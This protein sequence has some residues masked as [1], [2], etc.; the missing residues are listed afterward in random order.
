MMRM[1]AR[2]VLVV[3]LPPF[4]GG[5]P[6]K[7]RILCRTLRERGHMVTVAWYA[8][9]R[10]HPDLNVPSWALLSGRRPAMAQ[11]TCFGD[12][13]SRAVGCWL[14]EL[15]APYYRLSSRWQSLIDSH[16]RHIAVGGPPMV[17]HILA[18]ARVPHLLWCASDVMADRRDRQKSMGLIRGMVDAMITRPWLRAQQAY[19]LRSG[20]RMLGVSSYTVRQLLAHGAPPER[21][22]RLPIPVD[23][24]IFTPPASSAQAAILGFAARF[25]DPRK[26]LGLLLA[27]VASTAPGSAN[28]T[29][30]SATFNPSP[31]ILG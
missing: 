5:V 29:M 24:R 15:E 2:K 6:A 1:A 19:L 13:P 17:G 26:N 14:P 25:E 3:T 21:T 23:C 8:T 9:F 20:S 11:E 30:S 22:G 4:E 31:T 7:T 12:F 18:Q 27:A 28:P 16:D 10:Y